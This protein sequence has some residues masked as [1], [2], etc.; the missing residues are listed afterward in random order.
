MS[1]PRSII[2]GM[3]ANSDPL[4]ESVRIDDMLDECGCG[5]G[6]LM[7]SCMAMG[8]PSAAEIDGKPVGAD[9]AVQGDISTRLKAFESGDMAQGQIVV[10]F[11]E[12]VDTGLIN[13]LSGEYTTT[14]MKLAQNGL[15]QVRED[16]GVAG[17][18]EPAGS[19]GPGYDPAYK[20][21][22]ANTDPEHGEDP[23]DI[24]DAEGSTAAGHGSVDSDPMSVKPSTGGY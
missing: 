24:P 14:A 17:I 11:Q 10:L 3:T 16:L 18:P 5:C 22:G 1:D 7:G 9:G 21:P 8:E 2:R 6:G 19:T 13:H 23:A 12:L 4:S 20:D 15:I